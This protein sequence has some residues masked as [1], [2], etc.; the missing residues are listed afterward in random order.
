MKRAA[1]IF[2]LL[3]FTAC[4]PA[5]ARDKVFDAHVH[6]W[7]FETS[8]Q[9]YLDAAEAAG[10]QV[11]RIGAI[12]GG[13]HM[14]QHGRLAEMRS[15]NDQLVA[16]A[17]DHPK[18]MPIAT[19]HPYDGAAA[20]AELERL[21]GLGVHVIKLHPHTQAFDPADPRVLAL[22]KRAGEL[23]FVV[24]V[25]NANILAGDSQA[26]FNLAIR[27]PKTHFVFNHLGGLGFRFWNV[28]PLANTAEGLMAD[29]IHFDLSA[30]ILLAADSP[31]EDEFV[32]TLRNVGIDNVLLGSDFPQLSLG[33][34]LEALEKLDLTDEEKRKIRWENA[35]RILGGAKS[36]V[37]GI[38]R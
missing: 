30:T 6:L 16:L 8:L 25:D 37:S 36:G 34:T 23:G 26:L 7:E 11:D 32:W 15:N 18:L 29:N 10:T 20:L 9:Q 17:A 3:L 5:L 13:N 12:Q 21:A 31:I 1:P 27:A 33:K 19:V 24:L 38:S 35:Q 14:A 28:L 2:A 22:C 4:A